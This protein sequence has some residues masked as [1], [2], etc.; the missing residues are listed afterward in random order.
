MIFFNNDEAKWIGLME[1]D[2]KKFVCGFCNALVAS[3][4]AFP[5]RKYSDGSGPEVG[6]IYICP[7]CNG[8][9]FFTP[10]GERFPSS[11]LGEHVDKLPE[12]LHSLYE[13][14]RRSTSVNNYTAAVLI[15]RK[16]LMNIAV[17]EG[18]PSGRNFLEYVEYLANKGFIP[19]N[20]KNWVD[21]IRLKGNEATH[22]IIL[23]TEEDAR[24]LLAFTGMLLKFIYEFPN[25]I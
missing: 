23:M 14:A 5:I 2:Q 18:A 11:A 17:H 4:K 19:P 13:E 12:G 22:E 25:M 24:L 21:R 20:G 9:T 16:L 10:H 8:P 1:M 7:N 6:G 3:V 15:C